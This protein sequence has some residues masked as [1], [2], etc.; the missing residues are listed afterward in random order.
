MLK[1]DRSGRLLFSDYDLD[2][3]PI[4]LKHAGG[5]GG[6]Y[7]DW[8]SHDFFEFVFV[9]RGSG[10]HYIEEQVY[11]MLQGDFYMMNPK[12]RHSYRSEGHFT[13]VNILMDK[14][15]VTDPSMTGVV[16]LPG[17]EECFFGE[18][19]GSEHKIHLAPRHERL[20]NT[21]CQR[22]FQEQEAKEMGWELA[23]YNGMR[24]LLLCVS[25]AWTMYGANDALEHL[26]PGPVAKS[27]AIIY[28]EF[29]N[30]LRVSDIAERVHLSSNYFGELFRQT[31]GLSVQNYINK[32]RIDRARVLL[33]DSNDG[34]TEIAMQV[35]YEDPNYFSRMFK[36]LCGMT[37][38][39]YRRRAEI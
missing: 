38:R 13:I 11:P 9:S 24:E 6:L 30:D 4:I 37:P 16:H 39:E 8:H 18:R 10:T 20:V 35:G 27:I 25:R 14:S 5:A 23:L 22:M 32:H 33:E 15:I 34:I 19:S 21:L 31:T 2:G 12:D 26:A 36:K 29:T 17:I 3:Y 7:H 1:N 28:K